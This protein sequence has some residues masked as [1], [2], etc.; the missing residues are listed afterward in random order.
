LSGIADQTNHRCAR[1]IGEWPNQ[2]GG[3]FIQM[4]HPSQFIAP[5]EFISTSFHEL[6]HWSEVRLN[7]KGSYALGELIAEI[8]AC[9]AAAQLSV[10][11]GVRLHPHL[12]RHRQLKR[13][14]RIGESARSRV[15]EY[16]E[17]VFTEEWEAVG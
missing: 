1:P 15:L 7:W 9:Y 5:N 13:F 10:P 11:I 17:Q 2:H 14:G 4:P 16:D 12:F 6:V 3:D 8:G